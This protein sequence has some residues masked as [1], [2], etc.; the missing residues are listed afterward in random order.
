MTFLKRLLQLI[1]AAVFIIVSVSLLS[2]WAHAQDPELERSAKSLD[3]A[4]RLSEQALELY[5]VE[6][7]RDAISLW[8][9]VVSIIDELGYGYGSTNTP[10]YNIAVA[11]SD[12][13]LYSKAEIVLI[14]RLQRAERIVGPNDY[15]TIPGLV[16]LADFY[17]EI[18]EF[19]KAAPLY[20]RV[21]ENAF[22][23]LGPKN[24]IIGE[25]LI[26]L[27]EIYEEDGDLDGAIKTYMRAT[28][29]FEIGPK[30]RLIFNYLFQALTKLGDLHDKQG[31]PFVAS[32]YFRRADFVSKEYL[33]S[34]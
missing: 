5:E 3:D 4:R 12:A 16:G 23:T 11:Y 10:L 9:E 30:E 18:R 13:G 26:T 20:E 8:R 14:D 22:A 17:R 31:E 34:D 15:H 19:K 21:V 28:N 2:S 1:G 33:G 25:Y 29:V 32:I 6:K 27:G 7:F 24:Y